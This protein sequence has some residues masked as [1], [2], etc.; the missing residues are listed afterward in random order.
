[1]VH[2]AA[3]G[4]GKTTILNNAS[5]V[6]LSSCADG[7]MVVFSWIAQGTG[8]NI[9]IWRMDSNGGNLTQLSFGKLDVNPVCSPDS[10][11]VYY[12]ESGSNR[13]MRVPLDGSAKPQLVAGSTVPNTIIGD[14]R[15]SVSPDNKLLAFVVTES[16][17]QANSSNQRVALL[18]LAQGDQPHIRFLDPQ[19]QISEGP[20][21]TPD[22]KSLV[23]PIRANGVDNLWMQPLDGSAGRQISSF[24]SGLNRAFHW[25]PDGK[26][27]GMLRYHVESDVVLL[28]DTTASQ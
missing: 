6:G 16:G 12:A 21:F 22:G 13:I 27:L 2:V 28:R 11:T 23:Y 7:K 14:P 1:L 10:K 15:V 5:V 26:T 24:P 4:T 3:D 20:R 25:S 8:Q 9:Q 17:T 18:D 19:P